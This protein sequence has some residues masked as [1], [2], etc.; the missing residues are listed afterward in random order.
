MVHD[1]ENVN[2]IDLIVSR[3]VVRLREERGWSQEQLAERYG[4][5]YQYISQMETGHRGFG[6]KTF[7]K[8]IRAFGVTEK[9]LLKMPEGL[10]SKEVED[11]WRRFQELHEG[12]TAGLLNRV[13]MLL[14]SEDPGVIKALDGVVTVLEKNVEK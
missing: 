1:K 11:L 5:S 14:S 10:A 2:L 8:L 9:E 7:K 3:N 4:C 13:I 6:K 12:Q